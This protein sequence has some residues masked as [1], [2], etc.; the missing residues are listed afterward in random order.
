MIPSAS[1]GE[2]TGSTDARLAELIDELTARLQAGECL[3][4]EACLGEHPEH[5]E[6]LQQ[7]LPALRMLASASASGPPGSLAGPACDALSPPSLGELGDFRLVREVGR[8]GMGV[9]YEAEQRSLGRR[10]AL[11]VLPFAAT[12]DP[13]Q[14]QR[15]HN[16]ARAAACLHHTNIVPV[17]FVGC[18][19]GVHFYAMQFIDG[20]SLAAW[21]EQQRGGSSPPSDQPTTAYT[22]PPLPSAAAKET[23]VQA[24]ALTV[25]A[26]RDA[27]SFRRIAEWGI[28]AAEALDCAHQLGIVHRD[29]KPANLMVDGSGRLWVTDFGLAQVQSDTRL[30]LTGDL[31]GTLRYMSPEQALAKRVV[32]DHRSDIYSLGA[33]LYELLTLQ[34]PVTG[35]DRQELLRQIAFEEPP[36]PRRLAKGVPAELETIVLKAMEK[37]PHERYATAQEL[38][39][40]L[41][42]WLED[43]PIQA[44]RPSLAQRMR[45]WA[46]RNRAGV[47]AAVVCLLVTLAALIASFGFVLGRQKAA[48]SKVQ[49]AL[50]AALVRLP[51]GNPYDPVLIVALLQAEAQA[52]A[53]AVSP[54]WRGRVGQLRQDVD[55]LTRLEEAREQ[56]VSAGKD[57]FD[58]AGADQRYTEAF[59]EYGLDV[60]FP[61][62]DKAAEQVRNSA[63]RLPLVMALDHWAFARNRVQMGSGAPLAA[64]ADLADGDSWRHELRQAA[65]SADHAALVAIATK[66]VPPDQ[67]PASVVLLAWFLRKGEGEVM[68]RSAQQRWPTDFWI[69]FQLASVLD[70]M[71]SPNHQEAIRFYQAALALR[72]QSFAVHFNLGTSLMHTGRM[73]DAITEFQMAIS[74]DPKRVNAHIN[75]GSVFQD[76]GRFDD[77]IDEYR[78]IIAIYPKNVL[79][80][81]NL[82][83]AL[84]EK[85]QT[86][87]AI[88]EFQKAIALD[89]H[90]ASAHCNLG[91]ALSKKGQLDDAIAEYREALRLKKDYPPA[92]CGL[93]NALRDKGKVEEAIVEFRKALR[94]NKD[95]IEAHHNLGTLLANTGQ[96]DDAIAEFREA[97]RIKK[98]NP[99]VHYNLGGALSKKGRWDEA[100][101]EFRKTIALKKD[102]AEAH[103]YLG[104]ALQSKGQFREAV[105]ELGRGHELGSRNPNWRYPSARWLHQVEQL[106]QTDERLAAVLENKDHPKDNG[107]C[108]TFADLCQQPFRQRYAAAVRFYEQAFAADPKLAGGLRIP[109]RYNAACAAALAGCG[110]G[111]DADPS[112]GN[113]RARLRRQALEWLR[114]DLAA[115]RQL[116]A[117]EPDKASPLVRERMQRW[118]QDKDFAG[119]RSPAAL[120]RLTEAERQQWQKLWADVAELLARAGNNTPPRKNSATK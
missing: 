7:L 112:D 37:N 24:A 96:L 79:A 115:Y 98:D 49:E 36:A 76:K 10:V 118:Q 114:A 72:P 38:A 93:G 73:D 89:P 77:A 15:F 119:V 91:V 29:V 80:H 108:L 2:A 3:D 74:I 32:I 70:H 42:R 1:P 75:L 26:P 13:R 12:M 87:E 117:K 104:I 102:Y 69:S 86:E 88:S 62:A 16:E 109:H 14:L 100:I 90:D 30:T 59:R 43:K 8:G 58:W 60:A 95:Y 17:Y 5:A 61:D 111:K 47:A 25:R 52:E 33:T 68:L 92:Y 51:E 63:I 105:E 40:D 57:L 110:Q 28:Q 9:V 78:K 56:T 120:T 53:G 18:E 19:R 83:S 4:L 46:R 113:E 71:Q 27:A 81:N 85:N 64:V 20:H 99:E 84:Y 116:L 103:L 106:A 67:P 55:M 48:E 82:G 54:A 45:K 39:N 11:K 44:R 23:A 31:V 94:F 101:A 50:E 41:R 35:E 65:V 22:A 6:R 34:P 21:L 97:I 66:P 107:E